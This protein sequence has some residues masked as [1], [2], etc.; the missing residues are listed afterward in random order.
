ME[1]TYL[2]IDMV[3]SIPGKNKNIFLRSSK[4][5]SL[6]LFKNR[7]SPTTFC[8]TVTMLIIVTSLINIKYAIE[9]HDCPEKKSINYSDIYYWKSLVSFKLII[10]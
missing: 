4:S 3:K 2:I 6:I 5:I 9:E 7:F 1:F 8:Y 10:S